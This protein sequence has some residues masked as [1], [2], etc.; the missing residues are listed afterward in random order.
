MRLQRV[1]EEYGQAIRVTWRSY[2]LAVEP[3]SEARISEHSVEGRHRAGLEP[4]GIHFNPWPDD[5]PYPV[6][7]LPALK[8]G[9]C[10][11]LQGEEP[12]DKLHLSLFKT[13]FEKCR[14]IEEEELLFR[15]SREAGLDMR[16]FRAG[17]KKESVLAEVLA[18]YRYYQQNYL[19]WGVPFVMVG[20]RYPLVGAVPVEMYRRG[21][22][23]CLGK[24]KSGNRS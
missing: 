20:G 12:F 24:I 10:A 15:L 11:R 14:N 8:A 7:S 9:V 19:G 23:L 6:I 21:I 22:D 17:F 18:D 16:R 1:K 5:E 2:P 3:R 13:F 4:E